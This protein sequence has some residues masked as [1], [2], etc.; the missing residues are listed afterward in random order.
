MLRIF[1]NNGKEITN[2]NHG[3]VCL[4]QNKDKAR[5]NNSEE[6]KKNNKYL[7]LNFLLSIKLIQINI[8][9]YM[10]ILKN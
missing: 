3:F 8:L 6:K 5:M 1:I 10:K 4:K 7:N 2:P 9:T